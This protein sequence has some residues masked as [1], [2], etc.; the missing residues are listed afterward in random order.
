MTAADKLAIPTILCRCVWHDIVCEKRATQEDGLCDWCGVRRPEDMCDN[1]YALWG[2]NG[3]YLG[4]AGGTITGYNHQAGWGPIPDSVRPT[5]CW[6][7][8]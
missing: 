5:A 1:P 3:K 8:S 6:L 4:L 7:G 2:T